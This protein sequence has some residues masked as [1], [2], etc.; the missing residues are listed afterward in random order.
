MGAALCLKRL[1]AASLESSDSSPEQRKS[2]EGDGYTSTAVSALSP[3]SRSRERSPSVCTVS[4]C[5]SDEIKDFFADRE[6]EFPFAGAFPKSA[7]RPKSADRPKSAALPLPK[8]KRKRTEKEPRA[9]GKVRWVK[10][11]TAN[12]SSKIAKTDEKAEKAEEA[13]PYELE[14]RGSEDFRRLTPSESKKPWHRR[15]AYHLLPEQVEEATALAAVPAEYVGPGHAATPPEPSIRLKSRQR[16]EAGVRLKS[17]S[18]SRSRARLSTVRG[19]ALAKAVDRLLPSYRGSPCHVEYEE[20]KRRDPWVYG[21]ISLGDIKFSP[22]SDYKKAI[23]YL[24]HHLN[25]DLVFIQLVPN[26]KLAI[27]L[28]W[29]IRSYFLNHTPDAAMEAFDRDKWWEAGESDEELRA[30][31]RT[32]YERRGFVKLFEN[33]TMHFVLCVYRE[34]VAGLEVRRFQ[35]PDPLHECRFAFV[36]V[37]WKQSEQHF[38]DFEVLF[39]S[40]QATTPPKDDAV[41]PHGFRT[42]LAGFPQKI[43][44]CLEARRCFICCGHI[45]DDYFFAK[46]LSIERPVRHEGPLCQR[47]LLRDQDVVNSASRTQWLIWTDQ[48]TTFHANTEK[49]EGSRSIETENFFQG[50]GV[51]QWRWINWFE[52]EFVR[53]ADLPDLTQPKPQHGLKLEPPGLSLCKVS[54]PPT[55]WEHYRQPDPKGKPKMYPHRAIS[56]VLYLGNGRPSKVSRDKQW[57]QED[58]GSDFKDTKFGYGMKGNFAKHNRAWDFG[59][60]QVANTRNHRAPGDWLKNRC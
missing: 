15:V 18:R 44:H 3:E 47:F 52:G 39:Y 43:A 6:H 7:A 1:R 21:K 5:V 60:Q 33:N 28:S 22:Y 10:R 17:R 9:T 16:L 11:R 41:V 48:K 51:E 26:S 53:F 14:K 24:A 37:H 46:R 55:P 36:N 20:A 32:L 54:E 30:Y 34:A 29:A 23:E 8:K 2:G 58:R 12:V 4:S 42:A 40:L 45:G 19:A 50:D 38:H 35:L 25:M 31:F 49:K 57:H 59:R 13:M 27:V 56:H